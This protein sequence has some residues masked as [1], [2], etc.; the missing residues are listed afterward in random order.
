MFNQSPPK[1]FLDRLHDACTKR[2]SSLRIQTSSSG[3]PWRDAPC[4][5]Q[6]GE[7]PRFENV[8]T[9]FLSN[10]SFCSWFSRYDIRGVGASLTTLSRT[11]GFE[12]LGSTATHDR[13][14]NASGDSS[15]HKERKADGAEMTQIRPLCLRQ[16][17]RACI[18]LRMSSSKAIH[19]WIYSTS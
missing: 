16:E 18:T 3:P 2:R 5:S 4:R 13:Q 12:M 9:L 17:P 15:M 10:T 6:T 8:F 11:S 14:P 19:Q 7:A 1:A